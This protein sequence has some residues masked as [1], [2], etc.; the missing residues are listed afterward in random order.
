MKL[1]TIFGI[2]LSAVFSVI[3]GCEQPAGVSASS[4]G[5][6]DADGDG[7]TDADAD[8]DGDSDSSCDE[9]AFEVQHEPI[10]VLVVLDRS[11]SMCMDALWDPMVTA[12]TTITS[13]MD[14]DVNF[15]LMLFPDC[16]LG[17]GSCFSPMSGAAV[18]I[19]TPDAAAAIAT[20]IGGDSLF[21]CCGG[22]P[23]ADTLVSAR[24]YLDSADDDYKKYVLLATDGAPCCNDTLNQYT[25][26]CVADPSYCLAEGGATN[27]LDDAR[28][29]QSAQE[30]SDAGYPVF[31]LGVGGAISWGGVLDGIASAGGTEES[32]QV[33]ELD[34]LVDTF[35][36]IMGSMMS[37]E[38]EV[39]WDSLDEDA[40]TDPTQ[41][42]FYGDG[43]VIGFDEGCAEGSGWDWL[44]EDTAVLCPDACQQ[45]KDGF[46][47]TI[48]ATF[49]CESV[50]VVVE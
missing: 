1:A 5:D 24:T 38:F 28:T 27:C 46:W 42:N 12:V 41:V 48:T 23:T 37:C 29:Y 34:A 19:G 17:P 16:M 15:G 22:T 49:G 36:E 21:A 11:N 8:A 43:E 31:V 35:T 40:S 4:G 7:D 33:A 47:E 6:G 44:D 26:T 30:L 32:Y 25:C 20:E 39:D 3:S 45:L 18:P 2:V 9:A 14:D 10:D 50:P 13:E